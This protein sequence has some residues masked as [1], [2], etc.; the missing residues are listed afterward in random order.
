MDAYNETEAAKCGKKAD[1]AFHALMDLLTDA[2][3]MDWDVRQRF[4]SVWVEGTL[5]AQWMGWHRGYESA[6]ERTTV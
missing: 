5:N 1:D 3:I 2:G 6:S 4:I